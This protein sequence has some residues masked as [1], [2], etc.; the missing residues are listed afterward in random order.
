[1][2]VTDMLIVFPELTPGVDSGSPWR[3]RHQ[4]GR[5]YRGPAK[6]RPTTLHGEQPRGAMSCSCGQGTA[7]RRISAWLKEAP[8]RCSPP[9]ASA[10]S[11]IRFVPTA[12][13]SPAYLAC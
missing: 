6:A 4:E 1:M 10:Q 12:A 7:P 11:A 3:A 5:P 13:S 9:T 8:S 2:A